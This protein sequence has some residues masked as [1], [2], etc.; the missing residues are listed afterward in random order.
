MPRRAS[1]GFRS[2]AVAA[3]FFLGAAVALVFLA[4]LQRLAPSPTEAP[5]V[6]TPPG[7]SVPPPG[8][9]PPPP[10]APT[11]TPRVSETPKPVEP[12]AWPSRV[13]SLGRF[14]RH[15]DGPSHSLTW[16]FIDHHGVRRQVTCRVGRAD[17]EREVS[18]FGYDERRVAVERDARLREMVTRAVR[19][20]RLESYVRTRVDDG[21]WRA[22]H[23]IPGGL[24]QKKQERIDHEIQQFYAWLKPAFRHEWEAVTRDLLT[25]QGLRLDSDTLG[26]DHAGVARR[27][28][29][30]L[31]ECTRALDAASGAGLRRRLGAFI[32]FYQEIP[33]ERPP[34]QWQGRPTLGFYVPTEV[35][36][37]NHGD[38]DSKAVAFAAMWRQYARPVLLIHVPGHMLVGVEM[39]PGPGERYVR[40]GNRYFVLCEVAGPAKRHPGSS[41]SSGWFEYVLIEP[42][43][44]EPG[45]GRSRLPE[46]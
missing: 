33:Y 41:D 4:A 11:P 16:G 24:D 26:I 38:C 3:S 9:T 45:R 17:H 15:L 46:S 12:E 21:A 18:G 10:P 6:T 29:G 7:P 22:R 1:S 37:G 31:A 36:V 32:A 39:R 35:L 44:S 5:P 8:P 25:E 28:T 30:P 20:R 40:M 42:D 13:G 2:L 23:T 43:R 27:A 34:S 19:D 14:D